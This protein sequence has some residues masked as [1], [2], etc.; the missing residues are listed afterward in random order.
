MQKHL[1]LIIIVILT[2]ALLL[3]SIR[4]L[5]AMPAQRDFSTK[6]ALS[7][8]MDH[9]GWSINM[10][11]K[12]RDQSLFS[13]LT[14]TKPGCDRHVTIAVLSDNIELGNFIENVLGD[15]RAVFQNSEFSD[16]QRAFQ[17]SLEPTTNAVRK[18]LQNPAPRKLPA[19]AI[20][21]APS[22]NDTPCA[23][24]AKKQWKTWFRE[25]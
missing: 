1:P 16:N 2:S 9:H 5:D 10:A 8:F 24:P 23:P 14:Y 17:L 7:D 11:G 21:P 4:Y 12:I 20:S 15:D 13:S 18:L 22:L 19:I 25:R 3:K 6:H